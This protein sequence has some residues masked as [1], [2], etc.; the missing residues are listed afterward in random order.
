[1]GRT[2]ILDSMWFD[3]DRAKQ[4]VEFLNSIEGTH[5]GNKQ[6]TRAILTAEAIYLD[7]LEREN[8]CQKKHH[9]DI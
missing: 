1:M 9:R 8:A 5:K 6:Y 3:A 2:L 7:E 4:L